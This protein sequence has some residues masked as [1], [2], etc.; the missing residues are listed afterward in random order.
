M[1]KRISD[2]PRMVAGLY[3][4]MLKSLAFPSAT[5]QFRILCVED[6]SAED[7]EVPAA[8]NTPAISS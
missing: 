7:T 4:R 8:A 1:C 3:K 6:Y 2:N 5:M